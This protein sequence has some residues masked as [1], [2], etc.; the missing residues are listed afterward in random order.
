[1]DSGASIAPLL[2]GSVGSH[3]H[4]TKRKGAFL[5]YS[6]V[7]LQGIIGVFTLRKLSYQDFEFGGSI[8]GKGIG[9]QFVGAIPTEKIVGN[10]AVWDFSLQ[11]KTP[12]S[13]VNSVTIEPTWFGPQPGPVAH[14]NSKFLPQLS[15]LNVNIPLE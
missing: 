3:F 1:V 11:F 2:N 7:A 15:Q 12:P 8:H 9:I 6:T 10:E 14:S 4:Y 13:N 5:F